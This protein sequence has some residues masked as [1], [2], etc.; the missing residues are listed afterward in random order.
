M[1]DRMIAFGQAMLIIGSIL[2]MLAGVMM[3]S[4]LQ[5]SAVVF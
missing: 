1:K 3:L 4:V 2:G 5:F